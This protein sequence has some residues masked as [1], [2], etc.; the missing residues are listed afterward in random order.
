MGCGLK[1]LRA[2]SVIRMRDSSM[3][4]NTQGRG[5]V[6]PHRSECNGKTSGH[7]SLLQGI[8]FGDSD[9]FRTEGNQE[10]G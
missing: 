2:P 6:Y 8:R 9:N 10:G 7:R 5:S 3:I 4:Q 1:K